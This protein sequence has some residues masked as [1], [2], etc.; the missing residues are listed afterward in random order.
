MKVRGLLFRILGKFHIIPK[1][2]QF[3][4]SPCHTTKFY[5]HS[6]GHLVTSDVDF[7]FP[8]CLVMSSCTQLHICRNAPLENALVFLTFIS[9]IPKLQYHL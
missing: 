8:N 7:F 9:F 1:L 3:S 2:N 5:T 4:A 6:P